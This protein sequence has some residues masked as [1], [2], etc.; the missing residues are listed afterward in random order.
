MAIVV[1]AEPR[2]RAAY[3]TRD[4]LLSCNSLPVA[5]GLHSRTRHASRGCVDVISSLPR[6]ASIVARFTRR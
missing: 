5:A 4:R 1:V 2:D 6:I 3:I